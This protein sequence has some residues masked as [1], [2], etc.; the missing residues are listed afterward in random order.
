MLREQPKNA[1]AIFRRGRA[2][3]ELGNTDAAEADLEQA[4]R[5]S[6]NDAAIRRWSA[7]LAAQS[8][9][10]QEPFELIFVCSIDIQTGTIARA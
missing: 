2:H 6:P 5:L 4:A 10:P 3:L 1:K 8:H 9:R 7:A